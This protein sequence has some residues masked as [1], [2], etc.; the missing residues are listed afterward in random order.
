MCPDAG[1]L[2][3]P[4]QV[5]LRNVT[6]MMCK[7]VVCMKIGITCL[8]IALSDR[9]VR[10]WF[11]VLWYQSNHLHLT[12][13]IPFCGFESLT[14]WSSHQGFFFVHCAFSSLLNCVS[15]NIFFKA[16]L[17][18]TQGNV[19]VQWYRQPEPIFFLLKD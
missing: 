1:S 2:R 11:R 16:K 10:E 5:G 17:F 8:Y 14:V 12:E 18:S 13:C 7:S 6:N 15:K 3:L 4:Y 19:S 9:K